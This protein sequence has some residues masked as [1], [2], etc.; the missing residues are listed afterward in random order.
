MDPIAALDI[1]NDRSNLDR[2]DVLVE[3]AEWIARGG[4]IPFSAP[5]VSSKIWGDNP[6]AAAV[7]VVIANGDLS[8]LEGMG[9]KILR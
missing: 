6:L 9:F 4:F 1:I 5:L 7:N 2:Y 3:L 8:G